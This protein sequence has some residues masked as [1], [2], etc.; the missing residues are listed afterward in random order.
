MLL[1][2]MA[3]PSRSFMTDPTY[4]G[5]LRRTSP[6]RGRS[7]S[8]AWSQCQ[9]SLV[10]GRLDQPA[11]PGGVVRRRCGV[12]VAEV[13]ISGWAQAACEVAQVLV[14]VRRL[15]QPDVAERLRLEVVDA[16][17]AADAVP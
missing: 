7:S 2:D 16:N 5:R 17:D 15:A 10:R 12:L 13:D 4:D 6:G 1:C 14:R 9:R 3:A 11:E 8:P